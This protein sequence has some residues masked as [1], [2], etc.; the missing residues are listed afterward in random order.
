MAAVHEFNVKMTCGGCSGAVT[1]ALTKLDGL[2]TEWGALQELCGHCLIDN[3]SR[4]P[5][6]LQ[7]APIHQ[8]I[9]PAGVTSVNADLATQTVTVEGTRTADELLAAIKKTGKAGCAAA[10]PP[11]TAHRQCRTSA[12]RTGPRSSELWLDW[13]CRNTT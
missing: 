5:S 1:K 9:A 12:P 7:E 10:L 3:R 13:V 8:F 2:R 11:L 6:P 4:T